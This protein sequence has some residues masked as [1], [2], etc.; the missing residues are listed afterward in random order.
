MGLWWHGASMILTPAT[1][2]SVRKALTR[3][4]QH[5]LLKD[6]GTMWKGTAMQGELVEGTSLALLRFSARHLPQI[7]RTKCC[8]GRKRKKR[9]TACN[10]S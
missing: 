5:F 8:S 4:P 6:F 10:G 1:M 2:D 9:V 3:Q 7:G